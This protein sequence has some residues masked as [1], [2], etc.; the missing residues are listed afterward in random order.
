MYKKAF[1]INNTNNI[2]EQIYKCLLSLFKGLLV[3]TR[4]QHIGRAWRYWKG[5]LMSSKVRCN[6]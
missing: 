1:I 3:S 2:T 4:I 5:M 6:P